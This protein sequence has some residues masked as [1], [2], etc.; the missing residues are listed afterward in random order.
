MAQLSGLSLHCYALVLTYAMTRLYL[1]THDLYVCS[2]QQLPAVSPWE[3]TKGSL[4]VFFVLALHSIPVFHSAACM[5]TV[6]T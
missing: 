1:H 5:S 3:N 6:A 4:Q 2:I